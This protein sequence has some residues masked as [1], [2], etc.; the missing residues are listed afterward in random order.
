[1][2]ATDT[3]AKSGKYQR[4]LY[5]GKTHGQRFQRCFSMKYSIVTMKPNIV[6]KSYYSDL[7][8]KNFK[9]FVSMKARRCII[10]KGSLDN[11]LLQTK[12]EEIDSK[13]GLHLRALMQ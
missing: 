10:K 13:F 8:K 12:P 4:G 7:L 6:R 1:M 2:Y 9:I 3:P 5:H 11:Y